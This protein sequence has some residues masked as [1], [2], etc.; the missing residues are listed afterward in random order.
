MVNG[1]GVPTSGYRLGWGRTGRGSGRVGLSLAWVEVGSA[2][3]WVVVV[4]RLGRTD[5]G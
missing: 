1:F 3:Q 5:C 2:K 4:V